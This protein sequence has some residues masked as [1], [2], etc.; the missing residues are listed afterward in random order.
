MGPDVLFHVVFPRKG[1]VADRTV[2]AL[3][4]GVLFAVARSMARS[5]KCGR[6]PMARG[7]GARVLVLSPR[8]ARRSGLRSR[9]GC[10]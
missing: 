7:I 1:F 9:F 6:A 5:R 3:F 8:A 4:A 2:H 10:G